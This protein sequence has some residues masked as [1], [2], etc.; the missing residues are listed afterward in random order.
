MFDS[1]RDALSFLIFIYMTASACF[2]MHWLQ[3][4]HA[5][6]FKLN[7]LLSFRKVFKYPFSSNVRL[8]LKC[9]CC[10]TGHLEWIATGKTPS[11]RAPPYEWQ[12]FK[13]TLSVCLLFAWFNHPEWVW[14]I[15][16]KKIIYHQ[17]CIN[18]PS[19]TFFY[20]LLRVPLNC[21]F[22]SRCNSRFKS[23]TNQ[24]YQN[25]SNAFMSVNVQSQLPII[26]MTASGVSLQYISVHQ[27]AEI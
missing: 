25:H 27:L 9:L 22:I 3:F 10:N 26:L 16:K 14:W 5:E 19:Q 23:E 12:P 7:S 2:H 17:N 8:L 20:D 1:T 13:L 15:N 11:T 24:I 18:L 4:C 21:L 6:P